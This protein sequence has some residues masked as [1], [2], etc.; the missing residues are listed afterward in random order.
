MDYSIWVTAANILAGVGTTLVFLTWWLSGQFSKS[1]DIIF[2]KI[3][4][5]F[6]K[7]MMKLEYHEQHDD[8]R[9][10]EIKDD[11]WEVRVRLASQEAIK[12]YVGKEIKPN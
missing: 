7:L 4:A 6:D 11:L 5:V 9:F 2:L 12:K 3:D 8:K 1:R 10:S